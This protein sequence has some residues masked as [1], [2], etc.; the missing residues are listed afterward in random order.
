MNITTLVIL[1]ILGAPVGL[2]FIIARDNDSKVLKV[3]AWASV[4]ALIIFA[5]N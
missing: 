4:I 3:T 5:T 2:L 1:G